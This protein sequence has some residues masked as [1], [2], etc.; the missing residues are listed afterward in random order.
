MFDMQLFLGLKID[1]NLEAELKNTNPNLVEYFI[2]STDEYL[3]EIEHQGERFLGKFLGNIV[4]LAHIP[5][6][7]NNIHSIITKLTPKH[8]KRPLVVLAVTKK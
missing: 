3:H 7:E 8:T 4:E 5:L 6:I 1:E 2:N